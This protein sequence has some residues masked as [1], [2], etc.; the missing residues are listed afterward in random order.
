MASFQHVLL[1]SLAIF[2]CLAVAAIIVAVTVTSP[3]LTQFGPYSP[4]QHTEYTL[5]STLIATLL[6][7]IIVSRIRQLWVNHIDLQLAKPPRHL[8]GLSS[9]WRTALG[10]AGPLEMLKNY[11][12]VL[13][14]LITG[15]I[16]TS[17]VTALTPTPGTKSVTYSPLIPNDEP[18]PCVGPDFTVKA[19]DYWNSSTLGRQFGVN[20]FDESCPLQFGLTVM[21]SINTVNPSS[22]AY[23]DK[24]VAVQSSA[25]AAPI[26][27][28]DSDGAFGSDLGNLIDQYGS[29]TLSTQQCVPV[30]LS[31]PYQCR[32]GGLITPGA[33]DSFVVVSSDGT[34]TVGAN[35]NGFTV[36]PTM[37][38][39]Y[40]L[41]GDIGQGTLLFGAA[42]GYATTLAM[43]VGDP[44]WRNVSDISTYSVE[45]TIDARSV[46]DWRYVQL[47]L[48]NNSRSGFNRILSSPPLPEGL[49]IAD[50]V[51]STGFDVLAALAATATY[52]AL[53]E[54]LDQ[55]GFFQSIANVAAGIDLA[56][57]RTGPWA[58]EN[59]EN[60]L[61]DVLGLMAALVVSRNYYD[62]TLVMASGFATVEIT[63]MGSG[64]LYSAAF[65]IPPLIAAAVLV[66]LVVKTWKW[67][68]ELGGT[69]V[70]TSCLKDLL[71][72]VER[73]D[74]LRGRW[75]DPDVVDRGKSGNAVRTA[76][77]NAR[78]LDEP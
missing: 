45:C 32:K 35:Q 60:G 59:S 64:S 27:I 16:T 46:F 11:W 39:G 73:E 49:C 19:E 53:Q 25:I 57:S 36:E 43:T 4:R 5:V 47:S 48:Q 3:A 63:R 61:E 24:G 71:G 67:D 10:L 40:C 29:S 58:F 65:V 1:P 56:S 38:K 15:L 2:L 33:N 52:Q 62:A 68:E 20:T 7:T 13:S 34:C 72:Q 50:Y 26:S 22:Y 12:V 76:L 77:L 54:N 31:N 78:R 55:D 23:A 74:R 9:R 6:T 69:G 30:M 70:K 51:P 8:D 37:V 44:N 42:A 18:N 66:W 14:Y 21:G 17:I 75:E 41:Q 28:Y